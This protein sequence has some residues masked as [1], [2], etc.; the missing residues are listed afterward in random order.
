MFR[1]KSFLVFGLALALALTFG[2]TRASADV[3]TFNL[4][5]P[6]DAVSPYSGPYG[7]VKV[8]LTSSTTAIITFTSSTPP[9]I[10]GNDYLFGDGGTAG[11]NVNATSFTA[12]GITES[13]VFAGFTPT[14]DKLDSGNV[15]GFGTFNLVLDNKDGYKDTATTVSFTVTNTSGTWASASNV[16]VA[17]NNGSYVVAHLFVTA[18]PADPNGSAIK[19]GFVSNGGSISTPEPST[20]A[21]A[22]L[23]ALGFLG[24]GFRRRLK[25]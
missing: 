8:D 17:N 14:F 2:T 19:T 21:L 24:Y 9:A 10:N 23:G 4:T 13:N 11:V 16:L 20:M 1:P 22:G 6:N 18:D 25:K 7:S 15:D 3:T 5:S 12:S